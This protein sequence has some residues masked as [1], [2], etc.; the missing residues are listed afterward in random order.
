MNQNQLYRQYIYKKL[1][2]KISKGKSTSVN[3]ILFM[4]TNGVGL[5]HLTRTLAVARRLKV[6]YPDVEIIFFTTSIAM[7]LIVREGF[8]AYNFPSMDYCP[9]NVDDKEIGEAI[10]NQ[11]IQIVKRHNIDT[12]VFDGVFPYEYLIN[13]IEEL[14]TLD[15]IWIQR[16]MNKGGK[17]PVVIEGEKYFNKI[18]VPGQAGKELHL[19]E[20]DSKFIYVPPII[21]LKNEELL[22][23]DLVLKMWNLDPNKKTVY[24]QLGEGLHND[25][26]S[27]IFNVVQSLKKRKDLQII[28]GESIIAY[29][30]YDIDP[31]IFIIRDY[32]NSIYFNA[33][34][35]AVIN[36]SYNIF[37]ETLYFGVPTII[38]PTKETGTDDHF[39]R[40]SIASELE[41]GFV[42]D[43]YNKK[44]FENAVTQLLIP[45]INERMKKNSQGLFDN[46]AELVAKYIMNSI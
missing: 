39:A 15:P 43:D 14:K 27:L 34:D 13:A 31:S 1:Y 36:A 22:P 25:V 46:G 26:N 4:P 42:L 24:I 16:G 9:V 21:Y 18:I 12:L 35:F 23:R 37:H 2:K 40:A 44:K 28:L 29:K 5:G 38:F 20:K 6:M 10:K 7:H 8:L 11:I 17:S 45:K 19:L 33:F 32:P 30:R 41:T 3:K